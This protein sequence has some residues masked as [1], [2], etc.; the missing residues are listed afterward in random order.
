VHGTTGY[1]FLHQ[2]NGLFVDAVNAR[3]MRRVYTKL[4]GRQ[5][6]FDDQLYESKRLIMDT[7]MASELTVLAHMLDRIGES[8][9]RSRDFTLNS[10]RDALVEVVA[11]FPVYRTYVDEQ[12]WTPDDRAAVERAIVRA[13]RRNPAMD[14]TIFDFLREVLLQ[15]D[16]DDVLASVYERR[17]GYPPADTSE[18]AERLRFAMKFQQYTGPLQAKGLED[19]AFYRYNL[20]LSLND[21]GG[22]PSRFGVSAAEFHELNRRRRQ[23]WP[24]EMIATSTHD[25][26][27]GEDVRTRIDV[28]SELPDEWGRELSRW[29]RM[30]RP[31]RTLVDGE[32]APDRND[33]YRFY[34]VLLGAWP[35]EGVSAAFVERM[36]A[37]MI[38]AVKEAK[39]HSSWINPDEQYENA[40]R[41][42]VARV[43]SGPESAKFLA[44]FPPFQERVAR[45]GLVNSLSQVV[46]KI[47]SPGVP[48]FY[49]GTDLWDFNL[50]DPD[51]RRPV[52]FAGRAAA[53]DRVDRI[54]ALDP[55][56]RG[57]AIE[58][59]LAGWQ[60]GAIKLLL[61]TAALR[62]RAARPELFLDGDYLP[63]ETD[64]SSV[65]GRVIAFA[66]TS[67]DAAVL[68]VAPHLVARFVDAEHPVPLGDMWKTSR[69]L[70]PKPLAGLVYRDVFT[71]AEIKPV[72][73]H[74]SAWLFVGQVLKTL[75][76]ALLVAVSTPQLHNAATPN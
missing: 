37:Y 14:A 42:Y 59:L 60:D 72:M 11:G 64:T 31:A 28:L 56:C 15:R 43:L 35:I 17:D 25:T 69:V 27:L 49:Q 63:L 61:T 41:T 10:L 16:P 57:R 73:A 7:S 54:L 29:M 36:Q 5:E 51:N 8:N 4:T 32:P 24:Y 55:P 40:V 12:G 6:S 66:R 75:P 3:R 76:V 44:A 67:A 68:A 13:R 46:L 58:P 50:V 74:E 62:L 71:G 65:A 22:D 47:A 38:K 21:V 2:V 70:L 9:R 45:A 33:E 26:K 30:A 52:D 1:N 19:T 34:Q 48:D 53:L 18:S 20:L 23:D 39:L